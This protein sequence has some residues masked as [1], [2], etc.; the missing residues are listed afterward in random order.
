MKFTFSNDYK[1]DFKKYVSEL[2]KRVKEHEKTGGDLAYKIVDRIPQRGDGVLIE[3]TPDV[4]DILHY[5]SGRIVEVYE[6]YREKRKAV[7][8]ELIEAYIESNGSVP[9]VYYLGKLTDLMLREELRDPDP[10]KVQHNEY[11]ILSDRQFERRRENEVPL[12]WAEEV[13][14]DGIDYRPKTRDN[15]R[16]MREVN[17]YY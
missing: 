2:E 8:T 11:P 7:I 16:K 1:N 17:G 14:T 15:M 6:P 4:I 10:Y 13:G 12:K 3:G 5:T 9:D